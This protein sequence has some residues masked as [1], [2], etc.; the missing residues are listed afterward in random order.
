MNKQR[1]FKVGDKIVAFGQD[2]RI[3]KI[4]AKKDSEGNEERILHFRP[5]FKSNDNKGMICSI[6]ET[7][8]KDTNIRRPVSKDTVKELIVKLSTKPKKDVETDVNSVKEVLGQNDVF[9]TAT[10][11][12][13]LWVERATA[14]SFTKSKKDMLEMAVSRLVEEVALVVDLTVDKANDKIKGALSK[15]HKTL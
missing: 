10:V 3:L 11:L 9:E 15:V 7:S 13:T 8:I 2:Y 1:K 12:R 14:E 5:Y 6:P 4:E